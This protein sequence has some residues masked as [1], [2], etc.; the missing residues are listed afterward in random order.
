MDIKLIFIGI[1]ILLI[2]FFLIGYFN[3]DIINNSKEGFDSTDSYWEP[4]QINDRSPNVSSL[5]Y[6]NKILNDR[7]KDFK[8]TPNSESLLGSD[9][10]L[11]SSTTPNITTTSV[12][13]TA[14]PYATD[15]SLLK[16][17]YVKLDLYNQMNYN[18]DINTTTD[19]NVPVV[20]NLRHSWMRKG[21][22]LNNRPEVNTLYGKQFY[23][24]KR[25]PE[26]AIPIEY[27]H[28][29]VKFCQMYPS[30]YP[31]WGHSTI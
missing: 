3:R 8:V 5:V 11:T 12:F 20:D 15:R 29:P 25:Y 24:D 28:D 2:I 18:T 7:T 17:N 13:G 6:F 31:C 23:Y 19:I 1:S 4:E 22:E 26:S 21:N 30:E 9:E 14:N 10:F 16:D 27:A